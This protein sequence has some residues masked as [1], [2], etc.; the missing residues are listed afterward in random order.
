MGT[1]CLLLAGLLA[2]S[3]DTCLQGRLRLADALA[4]K[5]QNQVTRLRV[6]VLT[7]PQDDDGGRRFLAEVD[8]GRPRGIPQRIRVTWHARPGNAAA[9]PEV[10]PGSLWRMALVLRRP[11]GQSN[12]YA[13]DMELLSFAAG[14]RAE[15]TVRGNPRKI[16]DEPWATVAVSIET[17]RHRIRAGMRAA[18]EGMRYGPVLIALAIGDQAGVAT[19]DWQVFNRTG[20]SHL[21]SIS[22]SHITLVA[23]M[24]GLLMSWL[25][26]RV[27]WHGVNLA[28][29]MPA[30]LAACLTALGVAFG[31]CLL[32]GW[33]V[34]ARRTFFMLACLAAAGLA[35]LP[36]SASRLLLLAG[37][38]VL[39]LDP[40]AMLSAGF[41]LSFGAVAILMRV[42]SKPRQ[43]AAT[44]RERV[45]RLLDE[46]CR[47]QGAITVGLA[48]LL[49]F[50]LHQISLG[51]PLANAIAV[52]VVGAVVT[53]LALLC[54]FL[55]I[56]PGAQGPAC[57]VGW[58]GHG[59]FAAVMQ[60]VGWIGRSEWA[61]IYVAAA[62]W[63]WLLLAV[64]GVS[65][66]LQGRGRRWRRLGWLGMAP[67]LLWRPDRPD[68][69]D[70]RMTA[71]DVGQGS[72]LVIETAT[73][74]LLYDAGPRYYGG[75]DAGE[76]VLAP[77]L[78]ARGVRRVDALIVSH[79]DQDHAGG[80]RGVLQALPV[81]VSYASFDVAE[82]LK[83]EAARLAEPGPDPVRLPASQRPCEA[84]MAWEID[85]VL[86]SFVHPPPQAG[87]PSKSKNGGFDTNAR[88]C[89]LLVQ[90]RH[91]AAL[92][93]GDA[94]VAQ[95]ARYAAA[96]PPV[97]VVAAP[98]HGSS[99]SS[100]SALVKS[101]GRAQ[102][103]VQAGYLNR[104]HHPS[105]Q[106]VSRWQA[107]GA[108]VW[109]TDLQGAVTFE[110]TR[111][112]LA[113]Q[114]R[115]DAYR[116]YWHTLLPWNTRSGARPETD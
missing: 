10:L 55:S 58:L 107:T 93:P 112:G 105:P 4:E 97:D 19:G 66:A 80:L 40:W 11:Y 56:I 17:L 78:R 68:S 49:A 8:Q 82:H 16:A 2:G 63:P 84:G 47:T 22:G 110:S 111:L 101:V 71:L 52:P 12:P 57:A 39:A 72:A 75:G 37:V 46:F 23:A 59:L 31:Y 42:A 67:L 53:P 85:G 14:I 15:G 61:S 70:W 99:T 100:G 5:H 69:G 115:R 7:L 27:R 79:A 50:L 73:H 103:I 76:R 48:P 95:E 24:G 90:G 77:Y 64:G 91:H 89:V 9:L 3:F 86:L 65:L 30:Q 34:P 60:P 45:R 104:F 51:S 25:W 43:P 26:R 81:D 62:P 102:I 109:R 20:I 35:R 88:S 41:W 108:T 13:S 54:G 44:W 74:T 106:V 116:R 32:A 98:H 21:V 96:L 114:A 83:R 28:E 18:L 1:V 92:L 6:R 33:G 87:M 38:F 94:G 113:V 36:L 29:Y